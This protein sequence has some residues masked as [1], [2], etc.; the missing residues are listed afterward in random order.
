MLEKQSARIHKCVRRASHPSWLGHD[1]DQ[2]L[3]F[4]LRENTQTRKAR[5][6]GPLADPFPSRS[7]WRNGPLAHY[8]KGL[9]VEYNRESEGW[10][11]VFL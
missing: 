2:H 8:A 5:E 3:V 7:V 9:P 10:D 4:V 1:R 11:W 6:A